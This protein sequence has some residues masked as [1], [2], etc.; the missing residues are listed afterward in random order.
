MKFAQNNVDGTPKGKT[1]TKTG[2]VKEGN[3]GG[4]RRGGLASKKAYATGGNV[5]S[6]GK[7]VKMPRHFVSKPVA[8]SL[9]SGTFKR[10][11]KVKHHAEGG[12]TRVM[13]EAEDQALTKANEDAR[14]RWEDTQR[15]E[16]KADQNMFP[17]MMR[18]A[19]RGVKNLFTSSPS[20]PAGSVTK[21]EKSVTVTPE[22]K[23]SG[24][25]F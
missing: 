8:N 20:T 4:Y 10:G 3:A 25:K 19:V 11:G 6:D 15:R 23:R 24:G 13:S 9:Q 12:D 18:N 1:N 7:A 2:E 21:T 22:N 16:N 14:T 5:V 17:N